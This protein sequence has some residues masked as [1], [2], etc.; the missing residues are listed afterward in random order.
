VLLPTPVHIAHQMPAAANQYSLL[1]ALLP[2]QKR[3]SPYSFNF[4]KPGVLMLSVSRVRQFIVLG[5]RRVLMPHLQ[6]SCT[7]C[8]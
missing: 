7:R 1:H 8:Y 6:R 5:E 4:L 3:L 2:H